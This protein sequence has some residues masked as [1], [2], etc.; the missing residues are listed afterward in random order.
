MMSIIEIVSDLYLISKCMKIADL[1]EKQL[2]NLFDYK[3]K[4]IK[5]YEENYKKSLIIEN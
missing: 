3:T 5:L 4:L 1:T 2:D